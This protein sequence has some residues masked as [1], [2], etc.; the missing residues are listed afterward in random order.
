[1]SFPHPEDILTPRL[2]LI[3]ITPEAILSEQAGDNRLH[4]IIRSTIPPTWPHADWE[5][6]VFD[7]LL[8]QFAQHPDQIGWPRYVA[9]PNPDGIRT[10]IG[11]VGA[12]SKTDPPTV[13]EIGY[14]VLPPWEG[15][16]FAT[17]ATQALI[18]HLRKD[19]HITTLIAHT[20]PT[21]AASIRIMEKCGLTYDG[22]GEEPGT[23]R[24]KL[25]LRSS[26][27][28]VYIDEHHQAG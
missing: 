9:L 6:H 18:A 27:G 28:H 3:A 26:N 7:F 20:F 1:M 5:P 13:C 11:T 8:N 22:D 21:I 2:A 15:Q 25:D 16:G 12:F 4:E 10:L 17:E 19:R 23:I 24:Y 14:G